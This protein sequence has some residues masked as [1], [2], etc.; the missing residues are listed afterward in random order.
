MRADAPR[1]MIAGTKSGS[2]K[3]LLTC[4]FLEALV[5]R[6]MRPRAF[7][8]GPDYIDPMFHQQ[9]IGISS[10]NLDTYFSDKEQVC[11]LFLQGISNF[12]ISVLEGVMGLYDG[13]GGIGEEGSSY[14][15]A[16][17]LQTP[18]VLVVDARGMGQ[19]VL[20]LISGFLKYDKAGLI[21]GIILN[22]ISE[23]YYEKM[24]P[25]IEQEFGIT[26]FGYYK[27]QKELLLESR[28]LGLR[29]P[30]ETAGLKLQLELA[31]KNLEQTV[32]LEKI[33]ARAEA[34]DLLTGSEEIFDHSSQ[35]GKE[36]FL[37]LGEKAQA[38]R[39]RIKIAV[40]RDEAFCFYYEDNL[41]LLEEAGAELVSFSPIRDMALPEGISAIYLG[42]GYP[43]LFAEALS[44]N[45]MMREVIRQALNA[46]MPSVAECGGFMY[47]HTALW[48]A[49]GT[50]Y[51]MCGL[52]EG[53]CHNT[54]R[55]VRFGYVEIM[56][57]QKNFLKENGAI[58]GH[59]FHYYDSTANGDGC[60]V[61]KPLIRKAWEEI[62]K[63]EKYWWGFP[64][65]YFPSCPEFAVH[66]VEEALKWR[67]ERNGLPDIKS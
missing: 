14:A 34:V 62:H 16:M 12:G 32:A 10:R 9:I 29:L 8:S 52:V 36:S 51:E 45:S 50:R 24:K 43:E 25:V 46:G 15:L 44:G 49:K 55:L 53:E 35:R 41:R 3:T 39:E 13:L 38:D 1:I 67:R 40:A 59:E 27:Q 18:I 47:L 17:A 60:V 37:S 33:I 28:H 21:C 57:K 61:K 48:D 11:S 66:F 63:G 58:K 30:E 7:K 26:V 20:A 6:G 42:G 19:S 4:A 54:G 2:G 64:H 22:R 5:K 23:P 31:A 56:E 65:L